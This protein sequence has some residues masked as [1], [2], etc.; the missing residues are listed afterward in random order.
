RLRHRAVDAARGAFERRLRV[1]SARV[2]KRERTLRVRIDQEATMSLALRES[3]QMRRQRAL[4]GA[5]LARS[6]RDH[7]HGPA[8]RFARHEAGTSMVNERLAAAPR[9]GTDCM[10]P[11]FRTV[12]PHRRPI[13]AI[14]PPSR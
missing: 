3:R 2:P 12:R 5:A 9:A 11:A 10:A 7:V 6:K 8:L 14:S 13:L 4:A 1:G